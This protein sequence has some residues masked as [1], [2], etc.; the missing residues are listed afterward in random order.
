MLRDGAATG[1]RG[2]AG[3]AVLISLGR[4]CVAENPNRPAVLVELGMVAGAP[5]GDSEAPARVRL[6]PAITRTYDF[7]FFDQFTPESA[8]WAG[9]LAADGCVRSDRATV[10][11]HLAATDADHVEKLRKAVQ[12]NG[13]VKISGAA[14][15][16]HINGPRWVDALSRNFGVTPRKSLTYSLPE[17]PSDTLPHFVRGIIDGDGSITF[18]TV[19]TL[20]ITGTRFLLASLAEAFFDHCAV[21]LKSKNKVPPVMLKANGVSGQVSWSGKNAAKILRWV[22]A[23]ST[24]ATRLGRKYARWRE[25]WPTESPEFE[26]HA[27]KSLALANEVFDSV[28]GSWPKE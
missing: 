18:T 24:D 25:L 14:A 21:R 6:G 19:P 28:A 26:T 7:G 4:L 22:Y 23:D 13:E 1:S 16:L 5:F 27:E 20:S 2:I 11:L 15:S 17:L 8:Y 12:F 10:S 9:F 3:V